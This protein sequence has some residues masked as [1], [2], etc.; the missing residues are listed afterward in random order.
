MQRALTLGTPQAVVYAY[1]EDGEPFGKHGIKRGKQLISYPSFNDDQL[2]SGACHIG[3]LYNIFA[4]VFAV[5]LLPM[6]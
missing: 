1:G 2:L 5:F 4:I 3:G 6:N